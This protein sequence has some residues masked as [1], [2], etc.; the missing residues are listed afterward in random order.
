MFRSEAEYVR[1]QNIARICLV[2]S[3]SSTT[4]LIQ[5]SVAMDRAGEGLRVMVGVRVQGVSLLD[6]YIIHPSLNV[7]T[8]R[9]P[10]PTAM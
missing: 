5:D 4:R 7:G 6:V 2:H 9:R 10:F 1:D 8:I 3:W